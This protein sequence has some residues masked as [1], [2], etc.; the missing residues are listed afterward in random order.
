MLYYRELP[1]H[2]DGTLPDPEIAVLANAVT[3][4]PEHERRL[5][6]TQMTMRFVREPRPDT[7]FRDVEIPKKILQTEYAIGQNLITHDEFDALSNRYYTQSQA[8]LGVFFPLLGLMAAL[9]F[10]SAISVSGVVF[11]LL[12]ILA[13][14]ALILGFD[15]LHQFH[16]ELQALIVSRYVAM[17]QKNIDDAH[18]AAEQREQPQDP[19]TPTLRTLQD[20]LDKIQ[21]LIKERTSVTIVDQRT[22]G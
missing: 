3:V 18:K 6:V 2:P 11:L 15:R 1:R 13:V 16:S 20:S 5:L 12:G 17:V 21:E 22:R 10:S 19:N 9:V 8:T 7:S 4:P 14:A